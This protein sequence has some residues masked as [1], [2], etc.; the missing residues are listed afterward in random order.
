MSEYQYYEF[1]AVDRNLTQREMDQ[2]RG[3]STRAEITPTS[4]T[5]FY[6]FGNFKGNPR[7]MVETYFDAFVYV[8][9]WGTREL[10]LRLPRQLVDAKAAGRYCTKYGLCLRAKGKH[11]VLEFTSETED[12]DD[13]DEGTGWIDRLIPLRDELEAGD[14]R[15]LYLGWLLAVQS[16]ELDDESLEPPPPPGLARLSRPLEAL[17]EFL[18]ID[19][20]LIAAAAEHSSAPAPAGPTRE[21]LAGWIGKLPKGEKVALLLRLAE[22]EGK[23]AR[24]E[25]LGRFREAVAKS[26]RTGPTGA[27]ASLR[28][29]RHLLATC[30]VCRQERTQREARREAARKKRKDRK[31]LAARKEV[32]DFL[33]GRAEESWE[34]I[35]KLVQGKST[36]RYERA[37]SQLTD[38]RDALAQ[39]GRREEFEARFDQLHQRHARKP[40]FLRRLAKAGLSAK[41]D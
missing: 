9:N 16:R 36:K 38:L 29:V 19:E 11:V 5:N 35:E 10:M 21:E 20:D 14:L 28:T 25:L 33:A 1:R 22:G 37:V 30:E 41:S 32:L 2:L 15:A 34:Q 6:T 17:A 27:K 24:S 26:R 18:S 23:H 12:Y 39:A 31:L 3:L 40:S 8:A 13:W 4:F 7:R